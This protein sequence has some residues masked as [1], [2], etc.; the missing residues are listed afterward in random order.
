GFAAACGT[1]NQHHAV[2]FRD[3]AAEFAQVFFIKAHNVQHQVAELLAHGFF[4]QHAKH[5]IFAVD[6]GHDGNAEVDQPAAVLHAETTVLRH[7]TFRD[8][9]LTHYLNTGDDSRVMF[10]GHRLHGK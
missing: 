9:Q 7:A 2:R 10:L 1:G 8:I 5:G 4:I 3:V 6:G